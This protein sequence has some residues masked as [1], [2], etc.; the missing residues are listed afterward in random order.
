MEINPKIISKIA[1][2]IFSLALI[3]WGIWTQRVPY[4]NDPQFAS[5]F[6]KFVFSDRLPTNN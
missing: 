6:G 5:S 3:L 2:D 4:E 1:S